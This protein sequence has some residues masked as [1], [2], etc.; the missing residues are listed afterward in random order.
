M[1]NR[2]YHDTT[3][4]E[5]GPATSFLVMNFRLP[6]RRKGRYGTTDVSSTSTLSV[7]FRKTEATNLHEDVTLTSHNEQGEL[8]V[9]DEQQVE[10]VE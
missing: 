8:I 5:S 6:Q 3:T 4:D 9:T 10:P 2:W 1:D 7:D